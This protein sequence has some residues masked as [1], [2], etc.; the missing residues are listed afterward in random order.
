MTLKKKNSCFFA[1]LV[2]LFVALQNSSQGIEVPLTECPTPLNPVLIAPCHDRYVFCERSDSDI[3]VVSQ[4]DQKTVLGTS[5]SCDNCIDG[6][7]ETLPPPMTCLVTPSVSYEE[8][9]TVTIAASVASSAGIEIVELEQNLSASIGHSNARTKT[10][11]ATCGTDSLQGCARVAYAME[12]LVKENVQ[13]KISHTYRWKS[14]LFH[15]LNECTTP[16]LHPGPYPEIFYDDA[17]T[18][19]STAVGTCYGEAQCKTVFFSTICP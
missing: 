16:H 10:F 6:C 18:S 1:C 14:V 17:G 12:L 15:N 3:I 2:V 4:G 5:C 19:E 13:T 11:S 7:P 9:V 8:T